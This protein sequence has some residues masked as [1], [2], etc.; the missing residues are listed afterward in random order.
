MQKNVPWLPS[1]SAWRWL[2]SP[3]LPKTEWLLQPCELFQKW[4]EDHW[5][6]PFGPW[7]LLHFSAIQVSIIFSCPACFG[8]TSLFSPSQSVSNKE[9]V[10]DARSS[11]KLIKSIEWISLRLTQCSPE[12]VYLL[13]PASHLWARWCLQQVNFPLT[14]TGRKLPLLLWLSGPV[15]WR[16]HP[17]NLE[18][19]INKKWH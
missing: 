13:W 18:H 3:F 19:N 4:F 7:L 15:D 8:D 5:A 1:P 2:K 10:F 14:H 11:N 9:A 16:K 6:C 12:S 17:P